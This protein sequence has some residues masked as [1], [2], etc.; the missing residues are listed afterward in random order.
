MKGA[1]QFRSVCKRRMAANDARLFLCRP[2]QEPQNAG[3][4]KARR[5]CRRANFTWKTSRPFRGK[6]SIKGPSQTTRARLFTTAEV[7]ASTLACVMGREKEREREKKIQSNK[8]PACGHEVSGDKRER[9]S[10]W[11]VF[12][13]YN[14]KRAVLRAENM[15]PQ[16]IPVADIF[17]EQT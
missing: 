3:R 13:I 8:I 9:K 6:D 16:I 10:V 1:P 5:T 7:V 14:S 2:Q 4:L 12:T 17:W 15:I 11:R